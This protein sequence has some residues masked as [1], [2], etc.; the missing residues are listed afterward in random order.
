MQFSKRLKLSY[1][2]GGSDTIFYYL[3][4]TSHTNNGQEAQLSP[5]D[6]A[7][8]RVSWNLANCHATVQKVLVRQ[9]LNKSK[10]WRW[11]VTVGR[12]VI[13]MCTQ[14]WRDRVASTVLQVSNKATTEVLWISPVY[15]RLAVK[16]LYIA[17]YSL[18]VCLINLLTYWL[19]AH[20]VDK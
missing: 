4:N 19:S 14:P 13:N 8:R 2:V 15:R 17:V 3:E 12:C 5:R 1:A 10:L 11:R 18:H 7:M 6:R 9:V 16:F 20:W